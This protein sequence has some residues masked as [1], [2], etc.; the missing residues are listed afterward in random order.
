MHNGAPART[1]FRDVCVFDSRAGRVTGV[2]D[3]LV[4]GNAIRSLAP[5]APSPRPGE[6]ATTVIDGG[7]RTLMPGLIDAH[8]HSALA[9][10]PLQVA[11]TAD[12]AF[13]HLVAGKT[14]TETLLRGFT[15]VRDCGGPVF[16][17]KRAI[18]AGVLL[19]PRI[20]PSG[21]RITQSGGHG[22]FRLPYEIPRGVCG[23][24]AHAE[25]V[26]A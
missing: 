13:I 24:L 10:V 22:D 18:D 19:G 2:Q 1:L 11:M 25:L 7:R 5:A 23:C 9:A 8:W 26:G 21:A 15:T 12:P 4:E 16:G 3:V 14:A 20:F 17:L 6:E